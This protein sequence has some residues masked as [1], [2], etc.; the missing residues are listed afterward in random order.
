[1]KKI[2]AFVGHSFTEEDSLVVDAVLKCLTRIQ[3]LNT[4]FS[5]DHAEKAEPRIVTEKVIDLLK[6]KQVFI[7][8]CTKKERVIATSAKSVSFLSKKY[9]IANETEL[10]WKTSDWIIQEIGLAIGLGLK[11]LLV[12][13]NGLRLP[14]ALQGNLEH[15][16]LDRNAPEKCTLKLME[17]ISA[18][19]FSENQ[20]DSED[21]PKSSPPPAS[22]SRE[23]TPDE[24]TD[25]SYSSWDRAKF[26]VEFTFR[27]I[28]SKLDL[29]EIIKNEY[30]SRCNFLSEVER[31]SWTAYCNSELLKFKK[32]GS[33][34][35]LRSL[36]NKY[37]RDSL[38]NS[39]IATVYYEA[40]EDYKSA[41]V[42]FDISAKNSQSPK[43]KIVLYSKAACSFA[44]I[45]DLVSSQLAL[46]QIRTVAPS[47]SDVEVD[48]LE[49]EQ[50]V[51]LVTKND[52]ILNGIL[53]RLLEI[54]PDNIYQRFD[55]A[56]RYTNQGKY[57][58]AAFHYER[59][60]ENERQAWA[61][62]N[63]GVSLQRLDL[64]GK[65]VES[66]RAAERNKYTLAMSNL[67][68]KFISAGFFDEAD[69]MC[70]TALTLPDMH[71]NVLRTAARLAD[72]REQENSRITEMFAKIRPVS[73][74]YQRF[75]N[76]VSRSSPT[77]VA[78]L[79]DGPKGPLG[80]VVRG[81]KVTLSGT[82]AV[83][84]TGLASL[85]VTPNADGNAPQPSHD[86]Q[87]KKSQRVT[88]EGILTGRAVSGAVARENIT[89]GKL[90][91]VSS[92]YGLSKKVPCLLI[93][94]EDGMRMYAM[95][96]GESSEAAFYELN[97]HTSSSLDDR[98]VS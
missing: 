61:W 52:D 68:E 82:F 43:E 62:N 76:A 24:E 58:I 54:S 3:N 20:L 23:L 12:V 15:I 83:A 55:L 96:L 39:Y 41:A 97:A 66:F 35:L 9:I 2:R 34:E 79:W 37:P 10:A 11:V 1:M 98:K 65:S 75:G 59:I 91:L 94:S 31:D 63:L 32:G 81:A 78:P 90:E 25:V 30:S 6:D 26:E 44:K 17:M 36:A 84:E 64:H 69:E 49:A 70:A 14:G 40:F 33:L 48:I 95:E 72:V 50:R 21:E 8:I 67:A 74:F 46:S 60:P 88:Y 38:I 7:G 13:E 45:D 28:T 77:Y 86:G 42:Y 51:A 53:E 5:W 85:F 89:D 56:Y 57:S 92:M 87:P 19:T 73:D 71:K 29:A 47:Y 4:N 18:L 80:A 22:Q 27:V 93:I 16:P